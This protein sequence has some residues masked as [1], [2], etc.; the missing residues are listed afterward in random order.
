MAGSIRTL[1]AII[2][3]S[4]VSICISSFGSNANMEEL[5]ECQILNEKIAKVEQMVNEITKDIAT[6]SNDITK[7]TGRMNIAI[8][9]CGIQGYYITT[10]GDIPYSSISPAIST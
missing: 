6:N 10:T 4:S 8:H 7:M 9:Q 3:F 1:L 5:N 2:C